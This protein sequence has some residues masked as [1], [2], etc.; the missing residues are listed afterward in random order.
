[1]GA[2]VPA[3]ESFPYKV[4]FHLVGMIIQDEYLVNHVILQFRQ[5]L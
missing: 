2:A 3:G 4:I 5:L 1:M